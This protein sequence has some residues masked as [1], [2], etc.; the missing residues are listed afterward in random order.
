YSSPDNRLHE[1]A[2]HSLFPESIYGFDSGGYPK[3]IPGLTYAEFKAFHERNYHPS[4]ARI[5]FYGDDDPDERLRLIAAYLDSFERIKVAPVP[6]QPRFNAPKSVMDTFPA[7]HD[8][9]S[10]KSM[11]TVNWMIDEIGDAETDFALDILE[12]ILIG[13]PAGPLHKALV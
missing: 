2:Q 5:F 1:L 13:T 12:H 6:L 10:K 7:G 8:S 11:V 4:N 9:G 3:H